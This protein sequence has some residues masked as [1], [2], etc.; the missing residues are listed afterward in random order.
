MSEEIKKII[1]TIADNKAYLV[2]ITAVFTSICTI[3]LMPLIQH[4]F[5]SLWDLIKNIFTGI[6]SNR[7]FQKD[8]IK[9]LINMNRYISVLP[10][11]LSGVKSN[12][13]H[14]IELDKIYITLTMSHGADPGGSVSPEE[15]I[16]QKERIII[17][18]DPGAGK[19]TMMQYLALRTAY[20]ISGQKHKESAQF[21]SL[22][23][24]LIRLNRFRDIKKWPRKK[25]LLSAIS[26]E[27]KNDSGLLVPF[28]FWEKN[29]HHGRC[30]ILFD[31]FDELGSEDAR[32]ILSEKINNFIAR[33]PG[34]RFIVTGRI[35]GY[36]NQLA[37]AG[38]DTPYMIKKLTTNHIKSFIKRWYE[39]LAIHQTGYQIGPQAGQQTKD[40]EYGYLIQEYKKRAEN[41]INAVLDNQ[42]I[43]ELAINPMLLS[44]IALVHYVKVRLPEERHRL[45]KECIE[46]LVDQWDAAKDL[47]FDILKKLTVDEKKRILGEIAWHM[48]E[49][50]LKSIPKPDLIKDVLMEKCKNIYGEKLK[51]EE[52]GEFLDIIQKRTGLLTEKGFNQQGEPEISF[53]HLTFQEYLAALELFVK[54]K[55]EESV[56]QYIVEKIETDLKWWQE[57]GLLALSRF[58]NTLEYQTKLAKP[59]LKIRDRSKQ[60]DPKLKFFA[61]SLLELSTGIGGDIYINTV[62]DIA[63]HHDNSI[64]ERCSEL[65]GFDNEHYLLKYLLEHYNE[66]TKSIITEEHGI[67]PK[68]KE[69]AGYFNSILMDSTKSFLWEKTSK[70]SVKLSLWIEKRTISALIDALRDR[71]KYVRSSAA[72]ALGK[73]SESDERVIPAL[74]DALKDGDWNVRS[75]AASAL[76]KSGVS[77]ERVISALIDVLKDKDSSVRISAASALGKSGGSDKRVISALID[78]LRD[79]HKYVRSSAA[80]ALG[81][82]SESDERVIPAL[83][84]ALKDGDWN[85]RSS[86]AEALGESGGS[87]ERVISALIDALKD[88]SSGVRSSVAKALGKTGGSDER[89]ISALINALKDSD[90]SVRSSAADALGK[91]SESD[92]RVISALIDALKDKDSSVRISAASALGKSGGSDK[93]VISALIDAL[94]DSDDYVRIYA[95][96][97]LDKSDKRVIPALIDALQDSQNYLRYSA[98]EALIKLDKSDKR[99]IPALIDALKDSENYVRISAAE[100]LIKLDKS[101]E[102]VISVLI[103]ALK[104]KYSSV[105]VS[106][107]AAEALGKSGVSDERVISALL[108]ALKDSD[109][110]V[111]ISAAEALIKL[112]VSDKRVISALIYALKDR[113]ED[114]RS[115]AASALGKSGKSD[116]KVISALIDALKDSHENIRIPSAAALIRVLFINKKHLEEFIPDSTKTIQNIIEYASAYDLQEIFDTRNAVLMIIRSFM[117][118]DSPVSICYSLLFY[119]IEKLQLPVALNL[120]KELID[121]DIDDRIKRVVFQLLMRV[122]LVEQRSG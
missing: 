103:D 115:S 65:A 42:R 6:S 92:E 33:Y 100:A 81:K 21:P 62:R 50:H 89:V 35:T 68:S 63:K 82:L 109:D 67:Y 52:L 45:Y 97:A 53:S 38:F 106:S 16:K 71:H 3:L 76:G 57:P 75:S 48:H 60:F 104:Q 118:E 7:R 88:S 110:Y 11:T 113:D 59:V 85:V 37:K 44:L 19:T 43:R 27:I 41:L 47:K 87:D 122:E 58:K 12:T 84:D 32:R 70:L 18:G 30:I 72:D 80:D 54:F 90:R 95:A 51:K 102:R 73:L 64:V 4:I 112:G 22:I 105:S 24:I 99:V 83:I 101:D 28:G 69:M 117:D 120:L 1:D 116:Q 121:P 14:L 61:Q 107:S 40:D 5:K 119:S 86:A 13:L 31:A 98:A 74:I 78:A 39:N 77:D 29:L 34:N 26:D 20:N 79:R 108:D 55:D 17:L 25:N 114:V 94:K 23:P 8:Y 36:E 56:F 111:R 93:R 46:I 49:N 96:M 10:T 2:G 66:Q 15:I 91:L 9:W